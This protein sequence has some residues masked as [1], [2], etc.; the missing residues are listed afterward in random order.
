MLWIILCVITAALYAISTIIDNYVID[1]FFKENCPQSVKTINGRFYLVMAIIL[2]PL[3]GQ[4]IGSINNAI[5]ATLAGALM[6]LSGIPY[7]LGFKNENATSAAVYF[8]MQPLFFLLADFFFLGQPLNGTQILGFIITLTAP[9]VIIF[10]NR[11]ATARKH[12]AYAALMFLAH[13][14]IA[15][16]SGTLFAHVGSNSAVSPFAIFSFFVLG[17]AISDNLLSLL[18]SWRKRFKYVRR[19]YGAKLITPQVINLIICAAADFLYRFTLILVATSI[20]SVVTHALELIFT[21]I[22]GIILTLIW[23]RFGREEL[24]RRKILAHTAAVIL[25]LTGI[26]I[27]K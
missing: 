3:F 16:V 11:R 26:F 15:A 25:A 24:T 13:V 10:S 22:L 1:V 8:Q 21:F 27:L 23:P 7:V 4:Q 19:R 9:I 12:S 20:A 17:R 6:S 5:L 2:L 14:V 18:P